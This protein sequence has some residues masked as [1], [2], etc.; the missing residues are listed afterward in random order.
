[1]FMDRSKYG[2]KSLFAI[3]FIILKSWRPIN[4]PQTGNWLKKL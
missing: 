1:M 3:Q 4:F 2:I